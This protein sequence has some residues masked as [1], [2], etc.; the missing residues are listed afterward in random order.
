[1]FSNPD[2]L[3][4][5]YPIFRDNCQYGIFLKTFHKVIKDNFDSFQ[6]LEFEKVIIGAHSIIKGFITIVATGCTASSPMDSIYLRAGWSMGPIKDQYIHDKKAGDQFVK[7]FVTGIY[8]L[9]KDFRMS[10]VHRDWMESLSNLKD[11][12]RH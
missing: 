9:S 4:T 10:P 1:M 7:R 2:I 12:W 5:N 11:K 6:V 3:T 8:P